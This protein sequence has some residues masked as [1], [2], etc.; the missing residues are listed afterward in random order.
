MALV[1]LLVVFR[2]PM[3]P[4]PSRRIVS[5]RAFEIGLQTTQTWV[6]WVDVRVNSVDLLILR[7][8]LPIVTL[9]VKLGFVLHLAIIWHRKRSWYQ[10]LF[11]Q[12]MNWGFFVLEISAICS[13]SCA[14]G[15]KSP[16]QRR[17]KLSTRFHL[18]SY[19]RKG[20][21]CRPESLQRV[22]FTC[23]YKL[24]ESCFHFLFQRAVFQQTIIDCEVV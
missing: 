12:S 24:F 17:Y 2:E 3:F 8:F 22:S 5:R 9:P 4:F 21:K 14:K 20:P 18:E 7:C 1:V 19:C 13:F 15:L 16:V 11:R 23:L 6:N 10:Y